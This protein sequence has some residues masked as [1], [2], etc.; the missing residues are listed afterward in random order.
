MSEA[1][2][3]AY[4]SRQGKDA[5][6]RL[7]ESKGFNPREEV[8]HMAVAQYL[9]LLGLFWM[10]VPNEGRRK[11]STGARLKAMG[12]LPGVSDFIIFDAPPL[13]PCAKGVALELKRTKGGTV[14]DAQQE[15]L[16]RLN[17]KGWL[18]HIA[19]GANESLDY[20]RGLGWHV[21][22]KLSK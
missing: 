9:D 11:A 15:F 10:H 2:L 8:D 18:T 7:I 20:L 1:E 4:Q 6:Q 5:F 19:H 21:G 14:S 16:D 17:R 12:M 3:A 13:H 22:S